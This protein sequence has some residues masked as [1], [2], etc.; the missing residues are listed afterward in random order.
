MDNAC[1]H[2]IAEWL[3]ICTVQCSQVKLSTAIQDMTA[4]VNTHTHTHI[5]CM[6]SWFRMSGDTEAY[7]D[8]P[9]TKLS[10]RN[11]CPNGPERT[12]SMVPGSRST[13]MARG[14]NLLPLDN[15]EQRIEEEREK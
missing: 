1:T 13:R 10:G 14:T 8:S 3:Q 11:S 7:S 9:K 6:W 5:V 12:E 15:K 2:H 4:A